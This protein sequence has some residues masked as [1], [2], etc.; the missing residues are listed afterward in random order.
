[1]A[2]ALGTQARP[3]RVAIVGAGP[4]GFYAADALLKQ[5]NLVC[6]IDFF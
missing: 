5:P 1:M 4:A 2:Q 6:T 3:L